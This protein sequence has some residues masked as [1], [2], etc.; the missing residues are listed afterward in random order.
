MS[1]DGV[2]VVRAAKI[3]DRILVHNPTVIIG[4][5]YRRSAFWTLSRAAVASSCGVVAR[6]LSPRRFVAPGN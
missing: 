2:R 4:D 6:E 5:E 3:V 1:D